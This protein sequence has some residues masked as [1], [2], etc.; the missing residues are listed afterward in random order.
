MSQGLIDAL[1]GND[2]DRH[3][4]GFAI[5]PGI[6]TENLDFLSEGRVK[7]KVPSMPGF[8]PWARIS[9]VGAGDSRGFC[10][11]PQVD[12]EVLV[13]FAQN[14]ASTAYV[15]GGLWS[16]QSR[17]PLTVPTDF[18]SKRTI[19]TGIGG[20]GGHK[21]EFDDVLQ[22][23][24]ITTST[25][26]KITLDP[27]K[28]EISGAA[29]ALTISMDTAMQTISLQAAVKLELKAPQ[30][31]LEGVTVEIKG[32]TITINATGPCTVQGLPIKLN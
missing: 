2:G 25:E 9:S 28:I 14:D 8:E 5:A 24:T 3:M 15:L 20:A 1:A 10:W 7:V 32:A 6:V 22:S 31:S 19:K 30:I 12:D 4:D 11:I 29:G 26:Q 21:V 13:A 27:Q 17:P 18:L 16:T 23:V